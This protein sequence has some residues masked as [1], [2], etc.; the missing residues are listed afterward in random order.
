MRIIAISR[1]CPTAIRSASAL[2]MGRIGALETGA[3]EPLVESGTERH[4]TVR[5]AANP[6][7]EIR[8]GFM[9]NDPSSATRRTGRVDCNL[10]GPPPFAAH[11]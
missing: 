10:Y 8:R 2:V 7:A 6:N 5:I 4:P 11:G 1:N 3:A 9:A